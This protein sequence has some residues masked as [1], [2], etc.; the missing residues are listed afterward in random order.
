[1]GGAALLEKAWHWRW[2]MRVLKTYS[3]F[4]SPSLLCVCDWGCELSASCFGCHSCLLPCLPAM[5]DS[6]SLGPINPSNCSFCKVALAM[7]FYYSNRKT[8]SAICWVMD[9]QWNASSA[10]SSGK[11]GKP[12]GWPRGCLWK[13]GLFLQPWCQLEAGCPGFSARI[14]PCPSPEVGSQYNRERG[15]IL[16]IALSLKV[17]CRD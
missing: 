8:T 1:M 12:S 16:S 14:S 15:S 9:S 11:V 5:M 4:S 6:Y 13:A 10:L 2:A 17:G 3:T 7:V